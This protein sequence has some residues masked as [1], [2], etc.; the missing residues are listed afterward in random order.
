MRYH[1]AGGF[2]IEPE[3][4]P[5]AL[6]AQTTSV[7]KPQSTTAVP[8]AATQAGVSLMPVALNQVA[9]QGDSNRRGS[10]S[11]DSLLERQQQ[12]PLPVLDGER[13]E[14]DEAKGDRL[15]TGHKRSARWWPTSDRSV[16]GCQYK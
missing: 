8:T 2:L 5:F 11:L 6:V 9:A 13:M 4:V 14:G 3:A 16:F 1:T 7:S 10:D 15:R 12:A